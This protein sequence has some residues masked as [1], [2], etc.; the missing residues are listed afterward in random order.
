MQF[1]GCTL[2]FGNVGTVLEGVLL[3]SVEVA[4]G[5][6]DTHSPF[7]FSRAFCPEGDCQS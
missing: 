4:T 2:L 1:E 3:P 7:F 5:V 6:A